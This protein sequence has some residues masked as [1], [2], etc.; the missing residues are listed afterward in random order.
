MPTY[1]AKAKD[2]QGKQTKKKVTADSASDARAALREQGLFV[3]DLKEAQGFDPNNIQ[4][5]FIS[6]AMTKVTVKDKAVFS[7][8][9]AVLVN[10]G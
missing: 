1:V 2:S 8:Q 10:A 5:D 6:D 9:F 4:L 3:Q 7:R